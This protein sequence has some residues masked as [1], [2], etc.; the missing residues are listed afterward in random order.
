MKPVKRKII[1]GAIELF[2]EKGVG[3]V[4]VNNI[5]EYC[6]MSPGNL[7]YHYPTK[8]DL[9]SA[10][11]NWKHERI[12]EFDEAHKNDTL[13][14]ALKTTVQYL[15][16]HYEFR[17][18]HRDILEISHT[19][20]QA[21]NFYIRRLKNIRDYYRKGIKNF[22]EAGLMVAEPEVGV[23]DSLSRS[24]WAIHMARFA[25]LEIMENKKLDMN[26]AIRESLDLFFP[27]LTDSGYEFYKRV[28]AFIKNNDLYELYELELFSLN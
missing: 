22:V 12:A 21:K 23:Y 17:F 6:N 13:E 20:P 5:A 8:S 19:F 14:H 16:F 4:R 24:S 2:N 10:I 15:K 28:T 11:Y 18:A 25:E 1:I 26:Q 9:I 27:F 3:S 7:T